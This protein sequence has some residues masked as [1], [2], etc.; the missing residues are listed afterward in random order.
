[1]QG[2]AKL[3]GKTSWAADINWGLWAGAEV[4]KPPWEERSMNEFL[5]LL[6]MAESAGWAYLL[7]SLTLAVGLFI[8]DRQPRKKAQADETP[9][10]QERMAA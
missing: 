3:A 6:D 7:A 4:P 2:Q 5:I 1:M 8:F 9:S 10:S